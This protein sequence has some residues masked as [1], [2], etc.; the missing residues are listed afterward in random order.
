MNSIGVP[1]SFRAAS[2]FLGRFRV[3]VKRS[4]SEV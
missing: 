4:D 2:L 1:G 3:G